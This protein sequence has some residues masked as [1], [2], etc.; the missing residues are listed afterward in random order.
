MSTGSVG[1]NADQIDVDNTIFTSGTVTV[2][3]TAVE[4]KVG[5][6]RAVNRQSLYIEN[7]GPSA[8][9]YGPSGVTVTTGATLAVSQTV[10]LELGDALGVFVI[11][12]TA[13]NTCIVQEFA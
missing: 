2:G 4:A 8:I 10:F 1:V 6:T 13:G 7:K 9:F 5:A 11:A 3:T 12:N